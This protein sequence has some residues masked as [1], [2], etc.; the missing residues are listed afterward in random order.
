MATLVKPKAKMIYYFD[1]FSLP[2]PIE[3]VEHAKR[4]KMNYTFHSGYPFQDINSVRVG[5]YC[6]L[7]PLFS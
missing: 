3:F 2:P 1:S 6:L 7:L 4:L 5:Y